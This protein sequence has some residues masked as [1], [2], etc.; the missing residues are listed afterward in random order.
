M[1]KAIYFMRLVFL[2]C[3]MITLN[4]ESYSQTPARTKAITT[5]QDSL[6]DNNTK[7]ITPSRLRYTLF[8]MLDATKDSVPIIQM[9]N[10][11]KNIANGL[12]GLDGAGKILV[13]QL[14][15]ET[16]P[17]VPAW[18]KSITQTDTS[19]WHQAFRWG[20]HALAGY[21]VPIITSPTE[22]QVLKYISGAWRNS[23]ASSSP[24]STTAANGLNLVGKQVQLGGAILT[25]TTVGAGAERLD[26][27]LGRSLFQV[28]DTLVLRS[29]ATAAQ[30]ALMPNQISVNGNFLIQDNLYVFNKADFGSSSQPLKIPVMTGEPLSGVSN[31]D[32]LYNS[33]LGEFRIYQAGAWRSLFT[34]V[35]A[36]ADGVTKGIATF[37]PN[38]FNAT[39]GLI[40]L[41]YNNMQ[42]ANGS[43]PGIVDNTQYTNLSKTFA[44]ADLTATGDRYHSFSNHD[45]SIDSLDDVEFYGRRLRIFTLPFA[46]TTKWDMAADSVTFSRPN[47][48]SL[49]FRLRPL[50]QTVD[51]TTFKPLGIN[52][53]GQIYRFPGWPGGGGATPTLQQVL[54]AGATLTSSNTVNASTFQQSFQSFITTANLYGYNFTAQSGNGGALKATSVGTT[55]AISASSIGGPGLEVVAARSTTNTIETILDLRR[56]ASLGSSSG[57]GGAVDFYNGTSSAGTYVMSN[58][59]ISKLTT[60]T[61]GS[62]VSQYEIWGINGGIGTLARKFA[63]SGN[64]DLTADGYGTGART[65]TAAYN[66]AVTSA[67][68]LIE[69]STAGST[70]FDQALANGNT[71]STNRTII[72]DGHDFG[73][74]GTTGGFGIFKSFTDYTNGFHYFGYKPSDGSSDS[75]MLRISSEDGEV[76]LASVSGAL[77]GRVFSQATAAVMEVQN[78]THHSTVNVNANTSTMRTTNDGTGISHGITTYPD[79]LVIKGLNASTETTNL[80]F[81]GLPQSASGSDSVLVKDGTNKIFSRSQSA[82]LSPLT[83][84]NGITRS[85]ND[86]KLGGAI[87]ER[88]FWTGTDTSHR[89]IYTGVAQLGTAIFAVKNTFVGIL[90][91]SGAAIEGKVTGTAGIGIRAVDSATSGGT[92]LLATTN[93]GSA[94]K[95]YSAGAGTSLVLDNSDTLGRALYINYNANGAGAG[96]KVYKV[97][98]IFRTTATGDNHG[99]G[100]SLSWEGVNYAQGGGIGTPITR[101]YGLLVHKRQNA[102][103]GDASSQF[104]FWTMQDSILKKAL[105]MDEGQLEFSQYGVGTY[106]GTAAYNLAVTSA[107]KII[108]VATGGGGPSAGNPTAS[109]GLTAVNGSA[110]T[111]MRSDAAPPIDQAIAPVWTGTHTFSGTASGTVPALG[112]KNAAPVFD[113]WN[114]ASASTDQKRWGMQVTGSGGAYILRAYNDDGSTGNSSIAMQIF[115]N[116]GSVTDVEIKANN[117]SLANFGSAAGGT[118]TFGT[119]AGTGTRVLQANSSGVM[120]AGNIIA[121]GTWTPTLT[122]VANVDGTP[123]L[124]HS[125]YTRNG[126]IVYCQLTVSVDPTANT[127]QTEVGISLPIASAFTGSNDASGQGAGSTGNGKANYVQVISDATNDRATLIFESASTSASIITLSFQYTVL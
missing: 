1:K 46:T 100:T 92:G 85:T 53:L 42:V 13:S 27:N 65:G 21:L 63:I 10:L 35:D 80:Y 32:M 9:I 22:G 90:S 111:F 55:P 91:S 71:T 89:F 44:N 39:G 57:V 77:V 24:D 93:T 75:T 69:V 114:T 72:H 119:M 101:E 88:T 16:D 125:T 14:P 50:P 84:S 108:E 64:G 81:K 33:T 76:M 34:A 86:F 87:I 58:R 19:H 70:T 43:V 38:D 11:Q 60:A 41:D 15:T 118:I 97:G 122:G 52:T 113:I 23:S 3:L 36:A 68:K 73:W 28:V 26:F 106:T 30:I 29:N 40:S 78:S 107:G 54:T 67:G 83:A 105:V 6:P 49:D 115:R 109:V 47:N 66:L 5:I 18:V 103:G 98:T 120:S 56:M 117:I 7:A 37:T 51:T 82:I 94:I 96:T 116:G 79:S 104:E 95:A 124:L 2:V 4:K 25:P 110:G 127:T 61:N 20:N 112:I 126:S 45:L 62:E 99:M 123:T 12:A 8:R 59:L 121:S 74:H 48:T 102:D 17:T 31:G